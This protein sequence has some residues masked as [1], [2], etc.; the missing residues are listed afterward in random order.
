MNRSRRSFLPSCLLPL[1]LAACTTAPLNE[2]RDVRFADPQVMPDERAAQILRAGTGLGWTMRRTAENLI[3]ASRQEGQRRA[4]VAI[5][6][7]A[8]RFSIKRLDSTGFA[9]AAG[10]IELDF[11][12]WVSDLKAAILAQS[13]V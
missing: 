11:N 3:Q 10:E 4:L 1:I 5:S 12:R 13:S 9:Y 6:F 7:D 2:P 8:E